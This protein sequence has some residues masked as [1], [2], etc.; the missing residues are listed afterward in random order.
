MPAV[1]VALR[2]SPFVFVQVVPGVKVAAAAQ[3]ACEYAS[4]DE[5]YNMSSTLSACSAQRLM[6]TVVFIS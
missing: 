4:N 1:A 2:R 5:K 3:V 6:G